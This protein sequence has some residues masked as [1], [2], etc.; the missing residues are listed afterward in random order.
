MEHNAGYKPKSRNGVSCAKLRITMA[1]LIAQKQSLFPYTIR[2]GLW[3]HSHRR[4][5]TAQGILV[6]IGISTKTAG[7]ILVW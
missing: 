3:S 1:G 2:L 4:K 7:D 6:D 5:S